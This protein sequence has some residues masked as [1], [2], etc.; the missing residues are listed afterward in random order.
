M[1][2]Q[3]SSAVFE[4][5]WNSRFPGQIGAHLIIAEELSGTV[6][7]LEGEELVSISLRH[8]DADNTPYLHVPSIGLVVAGDAAYNDVHVCLAESSVDTRNKWISAL[9]MIESLTPRAVVAGHKRPGSE[10]SPRIVEET[11]QYI[12]DFDRI[13]AATTTAEELYNR[14][15]ALSR[16][17]EP[18]RVMELS[19]GREGLNPTPSDSYWNYTRSDEGEKMTAEQVSFGRLQSGADTTGLRRFGGDLLRDVHAGSA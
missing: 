16:S 19:A 9:D 17:I 3:A 15:L 6:I 8:T 5:F 7:K 13:A 12:R 14:M 10:D 2:H 1:R 4:S 11:R 18:W